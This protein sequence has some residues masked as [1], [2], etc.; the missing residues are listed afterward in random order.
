LIT[1]SAAVGFG[2][3]VVARGPAWPVSPIGWAAVVAIALISTVV[4]ILSFMAGLARV[5]PTDAATLSTLE[6]AMTVLLAVVVLGENLGLVQLLGGVLIVS[7]ALV[8]ARS[9]PPKVPLPRESP[10]HTKGRATY[11]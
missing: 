5:G 7:A 2:L 11:G 4:A 3:L 10:L 9:D 1:L 6:P 8:V